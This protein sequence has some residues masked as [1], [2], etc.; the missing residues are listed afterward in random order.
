LT[1]NQRPTSGALLRV[2]RSAD[3][4]LTVWPEGNRAQRARVPITAGPAAPPD[5]SLPRR[6]QQRAFLSPRDA[7]Q[8][9]VA[10]FGSEGVVYRGVVG[11]CTS[12]AA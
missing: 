10:D 7:S 4:P 11:Y 3:E 5:Q 6:D 12:S 9:R 8:L 1:V 2:R